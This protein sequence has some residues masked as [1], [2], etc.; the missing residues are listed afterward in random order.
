R[1]SDLIRTKHLGIL[2][3]AVRD[4]MGLDALE[5]VGASLAGLADDVLSKS[6]VM[7]LSSDGE[8]A[9]RPW[10]DCG[11]AVIGMGKLGGYE[12][13]YASDIDLMFVV[14]DPESAKP[15]KVLGTARS[16]FR[17]DTDLRPEGRS[18]PLARSLDSYAAYWSRWAK[19]WEFQALLKCRYSAGDATL[20]AGFVEEAGRHIWGRAFGADEIFEI[21]S[22]KAR[23]ESEMARRGISDLEVKRGRGGIRDI[24]FAVQLLQ[25]VHGR[26]DQS[27][28]SPTTLT[29][30]AALSGAGYVSPQDATVLD[31]AY[32]FLR[33]VE[34]RIQ[35]VDESQGHTVPQEPS[36]LAHLAR[37][38]GYRDQ[39]THTAAEAFLAA[40][41]RH[42][43]AVR[44]IHERLF[45]RPLLEVFTASKPGGAPA[46]EASAVA[47]RLGA[48]G[49]A[50]VGRTRIALRELTRGLT[51]SSSLMQALLPVL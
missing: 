48:F 40:L 41:G 32:R 22:M 15:L 5:Q 13:N 16:C 2:A 11:L 9:G 19:T 4:L 21:R 3:I 6:L 38:M 37:V 14:D 26:A 34:H 51:R 29:A 42:Q 7:A 1:V 31:R 27:I 47:A 33:Q 45:F 12:L 24:E 49:F 20:G 18:G 25:L 46:M 10:P 23:A 50:D 36:A 30:L 43:T 35:L 39:G 17:V 28:R 8:P 44:T